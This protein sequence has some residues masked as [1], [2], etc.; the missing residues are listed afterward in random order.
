MIKYQ[1]E[2]LILSLILIDSVPKK[3]ENFIHKYVQK[4]VNALLKKKSLEIYIK[5]ELEIYFDESDK[6]VP[7][8]E[9]LNA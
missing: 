7:H 2:I 9:S 4:N 5:E 8:K 1:K 3:G 6:E